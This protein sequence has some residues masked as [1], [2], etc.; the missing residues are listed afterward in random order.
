MDA[1]KE[2]STQVE[3][4]RVQE[5]SIE[6]LRGEVSRQEGIIAQ[7]TDELQDAKS[8]RKLAEKQYTGLKDNIRRLQEENDDFSKTN[9]ELLNRIMSEKEKSADEMNKM[10]DMMQQ[11]TDKIAMLESVSKT[12]KW[13]NW[14]SKEIKETPVTQKSERKFGTGGII[15]P[16]VAKIRIN[17]HQ[18]Q[19]TCVR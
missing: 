8:N 2:L 5:T 1:A 16:S 14:G 12:G 4:N 10:T 13:M 15:A 6:S 11:L 7:L 3:Q 9:D 19:A 18:S 17:A